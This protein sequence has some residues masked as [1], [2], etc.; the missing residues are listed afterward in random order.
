MRANA[1]NRHVLTWY[2]S[3]YTLVGRTTINSYETC[4]SD[5]AACRGSRFS[6]SWV[7][8]QQNSL[9]NSDR[10]W[11]KTN[12]VLFGLFVCWCLDTIWF[13]WVLMTD[14]VLLQLWDWVVNKAHQFSDRVCGEKMGCW[15][16]NEDKMEYEVWYW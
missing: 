9:W 7:I 12:S 11:G 2:L 15:N 5:L 6:Q 10:D 4:V 1:C 13:H 16:M 3:I 14:H 8:C